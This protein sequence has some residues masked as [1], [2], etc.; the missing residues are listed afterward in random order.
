MTN[1]IKSLVLSRFRPDILNGGAAIRN[2]QN[3]TALSQCGPVDVLT[4]GVNHAELTLGNIH[5]LA[6]YTN[7]TPPQNLCQKL[8]QQFK[9][10]LGHYHPTTAN[11]INHEALAWIKTQEKAQVL[12]D[13]VLVEELALAAYIPHLKSIARKLIFDAHN[14]EFALRD[15]TQA[16]QISSN[17]LRN[18]ARTIKARKLSSN[19]KVQE[20]NAILNTDE[21]W[22]CSVTDQNIFASSFA[23]GEKLRVIPNAI[24]VESY[25]SP[26]LNDVSRSWTDDTLTMVFV[27]SY[28][29]RPNS[30]AATVLIDEVLPRV[31]AHSPNAKL[32]L[33]GRDPTDHMLLAAKK[34]SNVT[35]T[36]AVDRI[37][38]YLEIPCVLAMPIFTGS[39]TRLK[40]L[41][42]FAVKRPIVCT[43]KAVEGIDAVDKLHLLVAETPKAIAAAIL[44]IWEDT[45]LRVNLCEHSY[46]LVITRYSWTYVAELISLALGPQAQ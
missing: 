33:V 19:L 28:S 7:T 31:R 3:V 37:A 46:K 18:F 4:I 22:V 25:A 35:V 20:R 41:E 16:T 34:D 29:Y 44:N 12:Y 9:I 26:Q 15:K 39:G 27:G 32:V 1:N 17:G 30:D 36:G 6:G 2:A 5:I 43:S 38:S 14:V 24:D 42:G 10:L 21:T 11:T 8:L 23:V 45:T 13:V 40:I